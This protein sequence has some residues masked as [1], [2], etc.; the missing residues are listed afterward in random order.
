MARKAGRRIPQVRTLYEILPRGAEGGKEF[1]RIVNLLLFHDGRRNGRT[2]RQ[3]INAGRISRN[4][5]H[6]N[7]GREC[8]RVLHR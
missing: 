3:R 1:A 8:D 4:G 5:P 2:V 7:P 6:L